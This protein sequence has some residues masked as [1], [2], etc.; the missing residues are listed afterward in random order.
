MSS[1][2]LKELAQAKP[3]PGGGAA[4]A[5]GAGLALAL[6]E[7]VVR[8]EANRRQ[9]DNC[10]RLGWEDTLERLRRISET[11]ARLQDEDV[12]AYFNLTRSRA[13][14]RGGE[15]LAAVRDAVL[16]PLKIIQQAQEALALLA[17]VGDNCERHLVSDL[18]V[19][20]EFLGAAL[21]GAYHIACANLHLV[22]DLAEHQALARELARACQ[23]GCELWQRVK[24]ELV[25]REH[26]LDPR[27]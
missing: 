11:M 18:L 9:P 5:Y 7:K 1:S 21:L 16:C 27:G 14:G 8:L 6:L 25:A 24:V 23:P 20:C 22:Q 19:A 4:A 17:W 12:Q 10:L 26:G 15:L 13:A 3:D 2:F